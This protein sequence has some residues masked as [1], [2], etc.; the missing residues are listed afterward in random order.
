MDSNLTEFL[1]EC[2]EAY[3]QLPKYNYM[4][5]VATLLKVVSYFNTKMTCHL[6]VLYLII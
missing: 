2:F 5:Q 1:T 4:E 3:A 6:W